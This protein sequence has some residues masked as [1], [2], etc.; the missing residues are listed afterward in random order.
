MANAQLTSTL[1][2]PGLQLQKL[3]STAQQHAKI[4]YLQ[5]IGK[6]LYLALSS[7]PEIAFAVSYLSHFTSAWDNSDWGAVK[8][9]L[10]YLKGTKALTL[11]YDH[12]LVDPKHP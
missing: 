1:I 6:L 8:H 11:V 7:R 12:R 3:K 4:P 2:E 10:C 5:A 9:L